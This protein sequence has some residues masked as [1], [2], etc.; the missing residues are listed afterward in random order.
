MSTSFLTTLNL[1]KC[2]INTPGYKMLMGSFARQKRIR[3]LIL[4]K[5][6]IGYDNTNDDPLK[7]AC[8]IQ[9]LE[10]DDCELGETGG[11]SLG[12]TIIDS[13]KSKLQLRHL[14]AQKNSFGDK[15][16]V[17]IA[18]GLEAGSTKI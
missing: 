17:R 4:N 8:S 13:F 11:V 6:P 9:H 14:S 1:S 16:A 18:A 3:K 7:V 10:L 12:Q 15:T 5:N 2:K